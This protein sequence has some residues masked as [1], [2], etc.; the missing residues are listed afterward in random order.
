[1]VFIKNVNN[2]QNE[3]RRHGWN[4]GDI[5]TNG[6]INRF[7]TDKPGDQCGWYVAGKPYHQIA[8]EAG[9]SPNRFYKI[10][11]GVDRPGPEDPRMV[12]ICKYLN[13]PI[14]D[15]FDEKGS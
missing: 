12:A 13:I 11:A 2:F 8:W 1:M 5:H 14:D 7:D 6:Q 10:T 3:I 15:V 9:I 4:P